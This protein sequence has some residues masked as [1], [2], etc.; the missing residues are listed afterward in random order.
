MPDGSPAVLPATDPDALVD[1]VL[2]LRSGGI[3]GI[4]TETVYGIAVVP[5]PEAL[6]AVIR[7]KQRP[8]DKGIALLIDGLDQVDSLVEVSAPARRLAK[9]CWP[10]ALTLV[11]PLRHPELM[12]DAV[13]GGRDT[14][15]LR[16]PDHPVPR[17]LARELGPIAV[18]SA[19]RFGELPARTVAELIDAV[20]AS[21]AL[22]LDDGPVRGGVAST[23]VALNVDGSWTLLREGALDRTAISAAL[24]EG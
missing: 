3:V 2:A 14:L 1:A 6:E 5:Q 4:P 23:V 12:P 9:R 15:G 11:L 16:I 13:T 7:A 24:E 20:G 18:T 10:G 21:L 17:T 8:E 22:V 19:N